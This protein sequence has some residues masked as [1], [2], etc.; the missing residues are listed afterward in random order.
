[1]DLCGKLKRPL[2]FIALNL[3]SA[4]VG[5]VARLRIPKLV[6]LFVLKSFCRIYRVNM[7]EAEKDLEGYA[8]FNAF[9]TRNLKA[10]AREIE[11]DIVAPV[12]GLLKSFGKV[13][14]GRFAE[15][16]GKE[17]SL[18]GLFEGD[19]K[20]RLFQDGFYFNFYLAPGDY[21]HVHSPL[22]GKIGGYI[23]IPGTLFPVNDF[24]I[25]LIDGIYFMNERVI[26][27]I[28]SKY[29]SVA[30]VKVGAFNVGSISVKYAP[31]KTNLLAKRRVT[32][33]TLNPPYEIGVGE[34]LATFN[35]GST[36]VLLFEDSTI[37]SS[38]ARFLSSGMKV[39]YG[40]RIA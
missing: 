19:E 24:W 15:V 12:D 25:G 6:L 37:P 38:R 3:P 13:S 40:L 17:F 2:L 21:H 34:R 35:L 5:A 27:L 36:V 1:M 11:G 10:G 7:D 26:T 20:W 30:V 32:S 22:S 29:G 31:L 8:T 9:F 4:I 14:E 33:V 23:Y 28:E 16:K 39:R 18:K